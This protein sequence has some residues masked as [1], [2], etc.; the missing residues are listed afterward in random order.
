[1]ITT[2]TCRKNSEIVVQIDI[3]QVDSGLSD[4]FDR[5]GTVLSSLPP[6]F[7]PTAPVLSRGSYALSGKSTEGTRDF[8]FKE[9]NGPRIQPN[10]SCVPVFVVR[11]MNKVD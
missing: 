4:F 11:A 2:H 10:L 8:P 3:V 9:D 6:N 1:M 7:V 5:F